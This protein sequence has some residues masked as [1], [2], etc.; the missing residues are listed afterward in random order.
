MSFKTFQEAIESVLYR[1]AALRDELIVLRPG[2]R[3]AL[4]DSERDVALPRLGPSAFSIALGAALA[5][6][7]PVLDLRNE[8]FTT[9]MLFDEISSRPISLHQGMTVILPAEDAGLLKSL[10]IMQILSPANPRQAAGFTRA[11]LR[12]E[13]FTL[14]L[15][16]PELAD[17]EDEI[18]DDDD[19][20]LLP[21]DAAGTDEAGQPEEPQIAGPA[22]DGY[23]SPADSTLSKEELEDDMHV[24]K[25]LPYQPEP[26]ACCNPSAPDSVQPA[27]EDCPA[28]PAFPQ[29]APGESVPDFP[30]A[31]AA[32][33]SSLAM[34][35]LTIDPTALDTLCA[36]LEAPRGLLVRYCMDVLYPDSAYFTWE[37]DEDALPGET[38]FLPPESE[39]AFL[40]LG[41]DRL[42]LCY[43]ANQLA[44]Q[45][46]VRLLRAAARLIQNPLLLI[47]DKERDRT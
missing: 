33:P 7:R 4:D 3:H 41:R 37:Y 24:G 17:E 23:F 38:A 19:F 15:C 32:A 14:L 8:P 21:A 20:M 44:P 42:T 10:P 47:Y 29:D 39:P 28:A 26:E 46:A 13:K 9:S 6:M 1:E 5:G 11:A 22:E 30:A 31:N 36:Q 34:R 18:P 16:N 40:W 43:D 35:S 25:L 45:A 2:A 27:E 12:S